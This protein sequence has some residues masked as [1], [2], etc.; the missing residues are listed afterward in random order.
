MLFEERRILIKR[1]CKIVIHSLELVSGL[2]NFL[3]C[4]WLIGNNP[5]KDQSCTE[6]EPSFAE[7]CL[8]F[9]KLSIFGPA[10]TIGGI[11]GLY[12]DINT[13]LQLPQQ[14]R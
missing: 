7:K 12:E 6:Q 2:S 8:G 3:L 4:G 11:M 13:P 9:T 14:S 5:W 1:G 10:L